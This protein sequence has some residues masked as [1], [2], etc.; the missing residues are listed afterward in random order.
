MV[1]MQVVKAKYLKHYNFCK[2]LF[3]I[4]QKSHEQKKR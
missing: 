1:Q 3:L 4:R 2:N